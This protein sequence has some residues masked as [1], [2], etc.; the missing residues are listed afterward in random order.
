M[1]N[2]IQLNEYKLIRAT[3]RAVLLSVSMFEADP[4]GP[5][6]CPFE[7]EAWLPKSQVYGNPFTGEPIQITEWLA[8]DRD[9]V[10]RDM[11]FPA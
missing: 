9:L 1:K 8:R 10:A 4:V 7:R 3:E 6:M 2:R 11:Q 5:G